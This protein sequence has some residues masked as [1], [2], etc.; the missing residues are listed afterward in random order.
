MNRASA[1]APSFAASRRRGRRRVAREQPRRRD[2]RR[3]RGLRGRAA[4]EPRP[5]APSRVP[6]AALR[7]VL[8]VGAR[9]P[10]VVH[11]V[12]RQPRARGAPLCAARAVESRRG[13]GEAR[14]LR[15]RPLARFGRLVR[16]KRAGCDVWLTSENGSLR[17]SGSE[18]SFEPAGRVPAD[19]HQA[20]RPAAGPA[21]RPL[22]LRESAGGLPRAVRGSAR[23]SSRVR[24][25]C[26][27]SGT[28][29]TLPRGQS[30]SLSAPETS[31]A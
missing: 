23:C 7:P 30:T 31:R 17:P 9:T 4:R 16:C 22:P 21:E 5:R 18:S 10:A 8:R 20:P 24:S 14:G 13:R 1:A 3:D 12:V 11:A 28:S 15:L 6:R 19:R 27:G 26:S 25:G 29:S 2:P